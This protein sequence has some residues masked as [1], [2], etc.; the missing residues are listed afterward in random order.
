MPGWDTVAGWIFD[1]LPTKR[2]GLLNAK[3]EME[4]KYETV[5]KI[6]KAQQSNSDRALIERIPKRLR[7]IEDALST[8]K[9]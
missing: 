4:R 9:A 3:K 6:P 2:E 1:R 8:L 7:E 5:R